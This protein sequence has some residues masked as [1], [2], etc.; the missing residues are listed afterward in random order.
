MNT[1]RITVFSVHVSECF[2]NGYKFLHAW[3]DN[4]IIFIDRLQSQMNPILQ[5]YQ[6]AVE[7]NTVK[8]LPKI[9]Y[10]TSAFTQVYCCVNVIKRKI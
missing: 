2:Y 8:V 7:T 5:Q 1:K 3:G 10:A 6:H 4:L 9:E